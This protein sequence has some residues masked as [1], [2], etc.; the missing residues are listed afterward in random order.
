MISINSE[1]QII[2]QTISREIFL[3]VINDTVCAKRAHHFQISRA[4]HGGDFSS[5]RFGD[6]HRKGPYTA[7]RALNQ[8]LLSGLNLSVIAQTLQRGERRYRHGGGC[9]DRHRGW[10]QHHFVCT[11]TRIFGQS[12]NACPEYFITDLKLRY[13]VAN[14]FN[15][16]RQIKSESLVFWFEHPSAYA[17][18]EY[19]SAP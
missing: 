16:S 14:P 18:Q 9:L 3:R 17:H 5:E 7:R 15:S 13:V 2:P 19:V 1:N 6:L 10:F 11:S 8:D 4:T 12:A